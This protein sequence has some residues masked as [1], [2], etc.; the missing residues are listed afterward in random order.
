MFFFFGMHTSQKDCG[1]EG[2]HT[3]TRCGK[4]GY[5]RLIKETTWM[6]LLF[7]P[8]PVKVRYYAMCPNCHGTSSMTKAEFE[9]AAHSGTGTN[10]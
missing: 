9:Q 1:A 3:C 6:I 8:I 4:V 10:S 5:W 2:Y 7:I